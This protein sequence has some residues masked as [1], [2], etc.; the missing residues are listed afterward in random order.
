MW[1]LDMG[2]ARPQAEGAKPTASGETGKALRDR[3]VKLAFLVL[4]LGAVAVLVWYQRRGLGLSGWGLDFAAAQVQAAQEQRPVLALF[5]RS[6]PDYTSRELAKHTISKN[7]QAIEAGR[8]VPVMVNVRDLAKSQPAQRYGV[9]R[10]PTMLVI[11]PDGV[12]KNRREGF[13]GELEFRKGF[14]DCSRVVGPAAPES[15]EASGEPDWPGS[16]LPPTSR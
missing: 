6:P 8:F 14:L 3:I 12:E 5:V 9:S 1:G 2:Q 10:L 11:G 16:L 15:P 7:A 13:V 4:T